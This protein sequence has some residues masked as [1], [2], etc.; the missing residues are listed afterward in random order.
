MNSFLLETRR[1]RK[2]YGAT[3][4]LQDVAFRLRKGEVHALLGANGS[5]KSTLVKIIAGAVAPDEGEIR[6]QGRA[7]RFRQPLEARRLGVA[8]VYQELSLVPDLSVQ[9]NIW[10]GHEPRG[11]WGRI[12][13]KTACIRTESLLR[14]FGDVAGERFLPQTLVRE[15]PPDE[16]Q[17]VEI[18]K[19]VSQEP[20]IL[21][22]DEATASL[23]ARQ[24]ERLFALVRQWRAQGM[25]IVIVTHRIEEI[26]QIADR[27]TVLRNGQVVGEVKIEEINRESLIELIS[28]EAHQALQTKA[29][30]LRPAQRPDLPL[31]QVKIERSGKLR[32]LEF[33]LYPGEILGLGGLQGQGQ[34]ELL[35]CL[36]GA[37]TLEQGILFVEGIPRRFSHPREAIHSGLAYVPGDRVREGLLLVRS[38]F[39]NL[40]LPSWNNYRRGG[41][42]DLSKARRDALEIT[43]KLKLKYNRLEDSIALLSGGN[44]QKVVLGRWLLRKPKVLLLDDPTKGIDVGA[45]AEFYRLL[46]ELRAQGMGVILHSSDDEELLSLCDRVLVMFEGHLVTELSGADL[47]HATLVRASLGF[48]EAVD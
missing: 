39:E 33:S 20:K 19:A 35:L 47:D 7:L 2:R 21:I 15:L 38:I 41:L 29:K 26:F 16:Q 45:K 32:G 37:L 9:D 44:A 17:L 5:G 25:A 36:F 3:I 46:G 22:L 28:G 8:V 23:D 48:K 42:L 12:N 31:L 34:R 24:V 43:Q 11:R 10:L 6:L 30:I 4:A 14:L 27:A 18:L 40:M 1:I 13:S